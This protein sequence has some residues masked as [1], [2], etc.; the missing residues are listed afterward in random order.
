MSEPKPTY[1]LE[2]RDAAP[3]APLQFTPEKIELL[4]RTICKDSTDDELEMFL[5][6]AQRCGLDPFLRQIH[7]VKR[8][9]SKQK[10]NVMSIQTGID[11][12]RLLADRTGRYAGNDEPIFSHTEIGKPPATATV[13]VYKVVAG[14]RCPFTATARWDEYKQTKKGGGLTF[15]WVKMPHLMLS[16]CAEALALR[17]AFPAEL[18]GIY[19]NTEMM[20]A[21]V[22]DATVTEIKDDGEPT[23]AEW[24]LKQDWKQFWVYW[25]DKGIT[26]EEMHAAAGVESMKKYA[27]TKDELR[28]AVDAYIAAQIKAQP[29]SEDAPTEA[30]FDA[31][32]QEQLDGLGFDKG[33]HD[34]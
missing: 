34:A 25:K 4:K 2:V 28:A 9:D 20:Q 16:K 10:R 31:A 29:E 24:T 30:Q 8:W 6:V 33:A 19:T 12:Y 18:S 1:E 21:D 32:P 13:T 22:I 27:G 26:R 3:P 5:Y 14:V 15:M 11:G 17:K 7:A 23:P